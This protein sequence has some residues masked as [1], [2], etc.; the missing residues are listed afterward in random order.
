MKQERIT[1]REGCA[2][3]LGATFMLTA[4]ILA[5]CLDGYDKAKEEEALRESAARVGFEE[6]LARLRCVG[7]LRYDSGTGH[8]VDVAQKVP[9]K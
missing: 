1:L 8:Y 2:A 4:M 9:R 5:Q 6:G 3:L 7:G